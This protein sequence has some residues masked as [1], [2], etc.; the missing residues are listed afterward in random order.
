ML[1]G[2]TTYLWKY[3]SLHFHA[4][5]SHVPLF[6][7]FLVS[8]LLMKRTKSYRN[9]V[10][11]DAKEH[12]AALADKLGPSLTEI[13]VCNRTLSSFGIISSEK[14]RPNLLSL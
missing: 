1:A 3:H 11:Q 4:Q 12:L 10:F 7:L 13:D 9:Y 5:I 6:E 8:S 14:C 2:L